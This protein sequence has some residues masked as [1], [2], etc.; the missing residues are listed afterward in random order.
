MAVLQVIIL[1]LLVLIGQIQQLGLPYYL[2]V[3]VAAGLCIYQ[4]YLIVNREKQRCFQAFLNNNWFGMA[5]FIGLALD[6]CLQ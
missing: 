2:G 3:L 6:Y 5:V 1:G 4:Q